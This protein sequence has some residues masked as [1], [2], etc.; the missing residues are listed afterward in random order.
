MP[1]STLT[2]SP[3]T[4]EASDGKERDDGRDLIGLA[5]ALQR[6]RGPTTNPYLTA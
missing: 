1:P 2:V 5:E 4:Q 6:H 3:V